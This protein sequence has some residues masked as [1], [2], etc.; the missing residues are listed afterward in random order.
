VDSRFLCS[1]KQK[2]SVG[3]SQPVGHLDNKEEIT[4]RKSTLSVD[5]DTG[6]EVNLKSMSP[7]GTTFHH[8]ADADGRKVSSGSGRIS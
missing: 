8:D 2:Q 5:F 7:A 3:R 4:V 6:L 1:S